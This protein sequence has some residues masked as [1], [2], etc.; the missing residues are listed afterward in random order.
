MTFAIVSAFILWAINIAALL[1]V[2][3]AIK[4]AV[5]ILVKELQE[6]KTR[7][8]WSRERELKIEREVKHHGK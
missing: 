7:L 5:R 2:S 8:H 4:G 6:V 1:L 3:L